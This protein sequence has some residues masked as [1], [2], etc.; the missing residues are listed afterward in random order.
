M[1]GSAGCHQ[2]SCRHAAKMLPL[3][4]RTPHDRR[5]SAEPSGKGKLGAI[6]GEWIRRH[7]ID[8]R[9]TRS[10]GDFHV[11]SRIQRHM[12]EFLR[13][14]LTWMRTIEIERKRIKKLQLLVILE[15]VLFLDPP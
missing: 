9:V 2:Q 3:H 1:H 4:R 7:L 8:T 6:C 12:F 10:N 15:Q 11:L 13:T 14:A 5:P